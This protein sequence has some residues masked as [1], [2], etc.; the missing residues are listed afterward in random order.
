MTPNEQRRHAGGRPRGRRTDP[1]KLKKVRT[2][3]GGPSVP[4]PPGA[5]ILQD[6]PRY[7][8]L[9]GIRIERGASDN[10]IAG[11]RGDLHS[12]CYWRRPQ[13]GSED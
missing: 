1:S 6:M 7:D 12:G 5:V 11:S 10:E 8:A 4:I 3:T 9:R 2:W 13:H